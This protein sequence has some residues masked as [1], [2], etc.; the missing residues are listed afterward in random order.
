MNEK[1]TESDL[2]YILWD[3]LNEDDKKYIEEFWNSFFSI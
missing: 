1:L 2:E 3:D